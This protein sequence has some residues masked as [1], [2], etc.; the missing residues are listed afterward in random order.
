VNYHA[1]SDT[2]DKVDVPQLK[3]HVAE[4]AVVA[5]GIANAKDRIGARLT[6]A[7]IDKILRDTRAD[8][9]LKPMGIWPEWEKGKRGR[10]K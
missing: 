8:E 10:S 9:Q 3:R 1:T 6:H 5:F 4:M 2:F 7:Q